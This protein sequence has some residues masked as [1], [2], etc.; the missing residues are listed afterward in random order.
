MASRDVPCSMAVV[1]VLAEDWDPV[2]KRLIAQLV[3]PFK[4]ALAVVKCSFSSILPR[5]FRPP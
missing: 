5:L 1:L 4:P 3:Q 2:Q